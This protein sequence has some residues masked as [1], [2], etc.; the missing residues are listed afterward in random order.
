MAK[1]FQF[2]LDPV[3]KLRNQNRKVA[4][5]LLNKAVSIRIQK[6]EMI[7]FKSEYQ[8]SILDSKKGST[9]AADLQSKIYH[10]DHV[11][12]EIEN[13]QQ[14]KIKILEIE[15][16]R[17]NKLNQAMQQ[18]KVISNLKEKKVIEHKNEIAKEE[19]AQMDEIS[20]NKHIRKNNENFR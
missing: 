6:D 16:F 4:E 11:Q 13:L 12:K 14:E 15:D 3:L 1:K 19:T 7:S 5:D 8:K 2:S 18:E 9:K 17:R 10:R 20:T